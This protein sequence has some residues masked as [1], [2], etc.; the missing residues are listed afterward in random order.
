M[1]HR[2]P[3][4]AGEHLTPG[5]VVYRTPTGEVTS[6]ASG[7]ARLG[8]VAAESPANEATVLVSYDTLRVGARVGARV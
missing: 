1:P 2:Y 5:Q 7:N 4:L 3:K 8:L 6:Q